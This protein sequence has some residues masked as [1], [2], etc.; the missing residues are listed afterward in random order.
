MSLRKGKAV[1]EIF[2][3]AISNLISCRNG[4]YAPYPKEIDLKDIG[5]K[6]GKECITSKLVIEKVI[7]KV[8]R[9]VTG[10]DISENKAKPVFNFSVVPGSIVRARIEGEE[11]LEAVSALEY[12]GT[13]E[14]VE[15]FVIPCVN[16][17]AI[18]DEHPIFTGGGNS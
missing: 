1:D 9:L 5:R 3:Y 2:L 10:W 6:I 4:N 8:D 16:M 11:D 7:G 17:L 13:L 15:S 14:R 18:L 12:L